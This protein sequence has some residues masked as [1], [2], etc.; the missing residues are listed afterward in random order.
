[1]RS[2][3][4]IT[5]ATGG[6]GKAF[7][8][9]CAG[10]GWNL[11]L[12]DISGQ[13]LA[14]L[15]LGLERMYGV[16]VRYHACNLADPDARRSLWQHIAEMGLR[17]HALINVA[18]LDHEGWFSERQVDELRAILCVN[19]EAAVEM[20]RCVLQH[21]DMAQNLRI[22]NVSSLAAFYPMPVKAVYA[23]SKRFLLDWSL[24]LRHELRPAGVTVTVLC[25][26][27]MRTNPACVRGIAAQG[28][29]GHITTLDVG[30]IAARTIDHALAGHALY[31]PGIVNQIIHALGG[32]LPPSTIAS[33]IGKRWEE[34]HRQ[35]HT[36]IE[37]TV[38]QAPG[39]YLMNDNQTPIQE[40]V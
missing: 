33:L 40:S 7:A 9:E 29:M 28:F 10:R 22:I 39:Q 1:M 17:F 8:V 14:P 31:I 37:I 15:A 35:S 25:P 32:L 6:L 12:T 2:Y 3:V 11:F 30:D 23:A 36:G 5:G 18:G 38:P 13:A 4:L 21:R 16:P 20:T 19:I 24:A 27:G 26:A 34:A